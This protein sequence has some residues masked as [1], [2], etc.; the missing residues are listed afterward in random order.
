M[1]SIV[2]GVLLSVV[3]WIA[4]VGC[5][6][7]DGLFDDVDRERLESLVLLRLAASPYVMM[8]REMNGLMVQRGISFSGRRPCSKGL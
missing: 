8:A 2:G 5:S 3:E 4:R 7:R 6:D 1:P